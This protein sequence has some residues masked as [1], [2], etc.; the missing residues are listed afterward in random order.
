[1]IV[2]V[3]DSEG[4]SVIVYTSAEWSIETRQSSDDKKY[5]FK[6]VLPTIRVM[7]LIKIDI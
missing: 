5:W 2:T 6:V 7:S 4:G 1:M 3:M